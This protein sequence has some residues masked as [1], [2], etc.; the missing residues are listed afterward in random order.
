MN[1]QGTDLKAVAGHIVDFFRLAT[2]TFQ[3]PHSLTK[4]RQIKS[5]GRMTGARCMIESGTYLGNTAR[6]CAGAFDKVITIEIDQAL[7]SAADI[8]LAKSPNVEVING[9]AMEVLP[10]VLARPEVQ[11][12]LVYLDGHFSG[13]DTGI[14]TQIEPACDIIFLLATCNYKLRSIIVDDFREFGQP[15]W[16]RKSELIRALEDAFDD[17]FEITVHLDQVIACRR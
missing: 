12:V 6:R 14:G 4:V 10:S 3:N 1:R 16:P 9:D 7:A 8:H 15:G 2:F 5:V 17:T 11:D 13:G